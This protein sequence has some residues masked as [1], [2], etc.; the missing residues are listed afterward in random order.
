MNRPPLPSI[1]QPTQPRSLLWRVQLA[2]YQRWGMG[3][4]SV[5]TDWLIVVVE[6]HLSLSLLC[7]EIKS[8]KRA[9]RLPKKKQREWEEEREEEERMS[10]LPPRHY[11]CRFTSRRNQSQSHIFS[12]S[13]GMIP[14][15]GW[16]TEPERRERG[17]EE[18]T[19]CYQRWMRKKQVDQRSIKSFFF[20]S[21]TQVVRTAVVVVT[22]GRRVLGSFFFIFWLSGGL[23]FLI[24]FRILINSLSFSLTREK[25]RG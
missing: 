9:Q 20:N 22:T 6:V 12:K 4:M 16:M 10:S 18:E 15:P 7:R 17:R 13:T 23:L 24:S 14:S 5:G 8:K 19:G 2:P 21:T 1:H 25:R 3:P 11:S